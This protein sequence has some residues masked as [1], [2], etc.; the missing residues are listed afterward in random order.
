LRQVFFRGRGRDAIREEAVG[1]GLG[2]EGKGEEK[3]KE[4]KKR[5]EKE[6][7]DDLVQS[8]MLRLYKLISRS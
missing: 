8:L 2:K 5:K 1:R 6:R 4:K 7:K 3:E